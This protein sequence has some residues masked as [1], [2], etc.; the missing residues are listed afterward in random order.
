MYVLLCVINTFTFCHTN[1][2]RLCNNE[3]EMVV[4]VSYL[5]I[6]FTSSMVDCIES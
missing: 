4:F 1:M 2:L 5:R 6:V 3:N